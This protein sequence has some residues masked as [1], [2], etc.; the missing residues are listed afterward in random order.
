[1]KKIVRKENED[2]QEDEAK[3]SKYDT[4]YNLEKNDEVNDASTKKA[5]VVRNQYREDVSV[6][7]KDLLCR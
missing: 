4:C 7:Q 5:K 6:E 1:M 3:E 2:I